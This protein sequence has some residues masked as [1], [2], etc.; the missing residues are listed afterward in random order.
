MADKNKAHNQISPEIDA[1]IDDMT[2]FDDDLMALVFD[3]NIPAVEC[4]LRII[5][6]RDIEVVSA[7]GQHELR[8]ASRT[9]RSITLDVHAIDVNGEEIDI[10]VQGDIRGA[11]VRRARFH[12]AMVDARMLKANEDFKNLK[13]SYIIFICKFDKFKE[14]LPIYHLDRYIRETGKE[15][16]DGSHIIY[17]N[18]KYKGDDAIGK[19]MKDFGSKKSSGM[20]YEELASSV[21]K[22]KETEKGRDRVCKAVEKYGDKRAEQAIENKA[23]AD[24]MNLMNNLKLTLNQALDALSIT[25][26]ERAAI[27]ARLR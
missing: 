7:K 4:V 8:R 9:G 22:F 16:D 18:G 14:G 27:I 6:G 2:L 3:K 12:S 19:L 17:V 13:D 24:V 10:E 15:V 5:L 21:R 23:V 20:H 11:D 25:G 1:I 26:V